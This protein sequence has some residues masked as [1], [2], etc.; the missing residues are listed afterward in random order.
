MPAHLTREL[1]GLRRR[2]LALGAAVEDAI[3]KA[4]QAMTRSDVRLAAQVIETD[5]HIDRDEVE[6][7]EECLKLLAL[8]QPVAIDL[9]FIITALKMNN[10]LERMGDLAANIAKGAKRLAEC[11]GIDVPPDLAVMASKVRSMVKR[12]LDSLVRLDAH[13]AQE[14]RTDDDDVDHLQQSLRQSLLG[15]MREKPE[16]LDGLISLFMAVGHLERLADI[17]TNLAEDVLY[18]VEGRIVRH[19]GG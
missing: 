9:R 12:S 5:E 7:E 4:V 2:L 19:A 10:D 18:M 14:V 15:R 1:D 13:L 6:V 3:A 8:Y 16:S 11:P 17:S